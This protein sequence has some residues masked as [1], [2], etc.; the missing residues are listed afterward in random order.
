[1][2]VDEQAEEVRDVRAVEDVER[3]MGWHM[4][5]EEVERPR[6]GTWARE[7]V[8]RPRGVL[9]V[10][11]KTISST[12]GWRIRSGPKPKDKGPQPQRGK[13][14]PSPQLGLTKGI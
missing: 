14:D 9:R 2:E 3:P 12:M 11:R 8:E 10:V 4:G 5:L 1:M 7:E 6:S 13:A